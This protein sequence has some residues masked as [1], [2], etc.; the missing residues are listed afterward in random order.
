MAARRSTPICRPR[1]CGST[2]PVE[3][4]IPSSSASTSRR[5][6]IKHFT[7]LIAGEWTNRGMGG[8]DVNP[9]DTNDIIGEFAGA[10]IED[11]AMALAAA[12]SAFPVWSRTTA[13]VR[14]D[15]LAKA[16]AELLARREE[17]G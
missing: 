15:V 8:R 4:R 7:N 17:I 9:S 14:S 11:A 10:S 12:R 5:Y 2:A 13:Q 3:P 16:A 1:P 6:P